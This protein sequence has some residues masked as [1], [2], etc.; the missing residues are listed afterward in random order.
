[1]NGSL[2]SKNECGCAPSLVLFLHEVSTDD[3]LTQPVWL[4]DY[5]AESNA[6]TCLRQGL[7]RVLIS[8][9]YAFRCSCCSKIIVESASSEA[10][11]YREKSLNSFFS[12]RYARTR[13]GIVFWQIEN[14]LIES[15]GS[16][17]GFYLVFFCS[18]RTSSGKRVQENIRW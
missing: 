15:T 3:R 6:D 17:K 9:L 13:K 12:S 1:M 5:F 2:G 14:I 10:V 18:S 7:F 16:V 8:S 4:N 11:T